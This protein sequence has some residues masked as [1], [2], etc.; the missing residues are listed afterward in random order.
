[1][2]LGPRGLARGAGW[3]IIHTVDLDV[4]QGL[5]PGVLVR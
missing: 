3:Y 5:F 2:E 1:M 4:N